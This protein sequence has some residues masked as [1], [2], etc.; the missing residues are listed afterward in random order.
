M[1]LTQEE[2]ELI[3]LRYQLADALPLTMILDGAGEETARAVGARSHEWFASAMAGAIG[4]VVEIVEEESEVH[5]YVVG[6]ADD[7]AVEALILESIAIAGSH[8]YDLL[9]PYVPEDSVIMA[10][11]YL[12]GAGWPYAQLC[13]GGACN[14]PVGTPEELRSAFESMR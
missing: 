6:A 1:W 13:V 14:R 4:A 3:S 9:D 7:P 8:G 11:A 2:A 5:I 12:P 10:E